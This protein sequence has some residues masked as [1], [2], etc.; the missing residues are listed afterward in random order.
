MNKRQKAKSS[1]YD[2]KSACCDDRA[3]EQFIEIRD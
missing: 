1:V 3:K 2:D